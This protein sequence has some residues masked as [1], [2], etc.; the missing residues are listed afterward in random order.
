MSAMPG[1]LATFCRELVDQ[2]RQR[3]RIGPEQVDPDRPIEAQRELDAGNRLE[4]VADRALEILLR[5]RACSRSV[6][7][8]LIRA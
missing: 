4:R 7:L 2:L 1:T 8:R 3:V 5:A 6:S